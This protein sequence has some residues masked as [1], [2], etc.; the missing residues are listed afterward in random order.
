M[1]A[2][3]RPWARTRQGKDTARQGHGKARTRRD[4]VLVE[5]KGCVQ[6]QIPGNALPLYNTKRAH[7]LT[8]RPRFDNATQI[9]RNPT[10]KYQQSNNICSLTAS[11]DSSPLLS[12][13]LLRSTHKS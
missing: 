3:G 12:A 6:N 10:K 13:E 1:A 8:T 4:C 9:L 11:R 7:A 2:I 5:Y